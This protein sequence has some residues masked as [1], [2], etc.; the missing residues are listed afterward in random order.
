M[1]AVLRF[2]KA[3]PMA[4]GVGFSCL[5]TSASDLIVQTFVERRET[6]DWK[7]NAAFASFGFGY[8]GIVQYSL[9]VFLDQCVHHPFMYFPAFYMT[10]ELVLYGGD[11]S[12]DRVYK[13]WNDNFWPDLEALWKIWVPATCLNFAFS[14]MWMRIPV[15]DGAAAFVGEEEDAAG[16]V[17]LGPHVSARTMEVFAQGL[18]RRHSLP[19]MADVANAVTRRLSRSD[20]PAEEGVAKPRPRTQD[21][22][23]LC[24]TASGK[25]R[26]GLVSMLSQWIYERGG[27]ITG[28]KMLRMNDEFTVILHVTSKDRVAAS[29]LRADLLGREGA[30]KQME[31]LTISARELR[32]H[33]SH[34]DADSTVREARVRLTGADQPGIVFKVSKLFSEVGFNIEELAT[35]T[36][37]VANEDGK[38]RPFFLLEGYLTAPKVVPPAELEKKLDKLREDLDCKI[39]A[40]W[41]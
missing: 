18:A 26:V 32:V 35:D 34:A 30:N 37:A 33:G 14:P 5:K 13:R 11:A 21:V 6:I 19:E 9:Y 12:V 7:R 23:H 4:F 38:T 28:S 41:S 1:A 17:M 27:N 16:L 25:D 15:E 24:V 39:T 31:D 10:K 22:A 3:S 20:T 29:H 36:V 8:L 2:A 40:T